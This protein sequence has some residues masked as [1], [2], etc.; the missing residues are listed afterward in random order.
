MLRLLCGRYEGSFHIA[1]DFP[2]PVASGFYCLNLNDKLPGGDSPFELCSGRCQNVCDAPL[3]RLF[4]LENP[5][6]EL[7]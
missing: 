1:H 6:K 3:A 2:P 4:V 5:V 7:E